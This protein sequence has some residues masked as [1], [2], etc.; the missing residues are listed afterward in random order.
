MTTNDGNAILFTKTIWD[1]AHFASLRL[2]Y[3]ADKV[4][5][6]DHLLPDDT[7]SLGQ[8]RRMITLVPWIIFLDELKTTKA[9]KW[10]DERVLRRAIYTYI[11]DIKAHA[12]TPPTLTS[13]N[14]ML[15]LKMPR[16]PFPPPPLLTPAPPSLLFVQNPLTGGTLPLL[17]LFLIPTPTTLIPP[18]CP[19]SPLTLSPLALAIS[20]LMN[21]ILLG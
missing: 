12:R 16:T 11:K 9:S 3:L 1:L 14:F 13:L 19:P 20:D 2:Q 10:E 7:D 15:L 4:K 17:P 5:Y 21:L 18:P 6:I 8:Q